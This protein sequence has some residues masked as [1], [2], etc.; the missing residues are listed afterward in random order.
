MS[1]VSIERFEILPQNQPSNNTYSFSRGTPIITFSLG[2]QPKNLRPSS[3]RLNGKFTIK[4]GDGSRPNNQSLKSDGTTGTVEINDRVGIHSCFQNVN[5]SSN[6]TQ[7]T[8]EAIRS[9]GRLS[10][11]VLPSTHDSSDFMCQAGLVSGNTGLKTSTDVMLNNTRSFS[12][13]IYSGLLMGGNTIPLSLVKGLHFSFELASDN[14]VLFG[15]DASGGA[16][17]EL[18]DLSMTGDL[19]VMDVEGTS[20]LSIPSS[21]SMEYNSFSNLYSVLDS[22]DTTQTYNLNSSNV[23]SVFSN[24]I[25]VTHSN[26]Y[27]EDGF[28]T[29]MLKNT[30][31]T[32]T[33]YDS[34][35]VLK[36][37]GFSRGGIRLGLDYDLV[38]EKQSSEQRPETGVMLNALDAVRRVGS[39]TS[40]LSQPLLLG[41]GGGD[42]IIYRK[43]GLQEGTTVDSGKRNF[44]IGLATDRFSGVGLD[45]KDVAYSSRIESSI[46]GK[47]PNSVFTYVLSKNLLSYSPSGISVMS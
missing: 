38:A 2:S 22:S 4:K 19:E 11:T 13:P 28:T 6:D 36:R 10:A 44:S 29:D 40:T 3:I 39:M 43:S 35:V 27:L 9:Y 24:F 14:A 1:V 23:L 33:T 47:S 41:Y 8:L 31:G 37:V 34:D 5:I 7:S 15:A 12:L 17:Y 18:S 45:F 30:D 16:I 20:K 26:T 25:P 21:G 42:Q 32:G 46:D